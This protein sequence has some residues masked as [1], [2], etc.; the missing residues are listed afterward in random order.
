[1]ALEQKVILGPRLANRWT[2]AKKGYEIQA[3]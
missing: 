2:K 1:M 3:L